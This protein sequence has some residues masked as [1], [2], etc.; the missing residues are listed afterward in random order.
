MVT[1]YTFDLC[2]QLHELKPWW[3]P[4]DRLFIRREGEL[5]GVVKGVSFARSLDQA[6]RFTI[7]YLLEKLPNRILDGF[8]YGM[9]TLSARQGSF[10][11]G[12]VASYDNDAGYPIGDICGV[13]ETA[14]DALLELAIEMIK[15]EEI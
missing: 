12:W 1:L 6:P 15:R 10:R 5:P 9:L 3:T 2:K 11:Y 7:D 14:L 4:E 8:D 13:A